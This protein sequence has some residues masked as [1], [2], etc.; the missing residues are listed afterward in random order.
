M[1]DEGSDRL[2]LPA[3]FLSKLAHETV[4]H[5]AAVQAS[6]YL[7][8]KH[9]R[10]ISGAREQE[11]WSAIQK[12][13]SRVQL[14]MDRLCRLEHALS[15][16]VQPAEV[17][18]ALFLRDLAEQARLAGPA[19]E[20]ALDVRVRAGET[21]TG[22]AGLLEI[23]TECLLSNACKF[24]PPGTVAVLETRREGDFL[25]IRVTDAGP[26]LAPD[27]VARLFEPFFQGRNAKKNGGCGLGLAIARAAVNRLG[28]TITY[29]PARGQGTEFRLCLPAVN[30]R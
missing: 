17:D 24:G 8:R 18:L 21:W 6:S 3:G 4:G 13:G 25:E 5:L 16:A 29:Q 12:A 28:G 2:S 26:G 19:T 14:I 22:D 20:V 11:W 7:L 1:T 9:G 30:R 27:E 15:G 10:E 23:A